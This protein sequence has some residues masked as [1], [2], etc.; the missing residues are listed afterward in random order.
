M[1]QAK[2]LP[3]RSKVKG[4]GNC[5]NKSQERT[6]EYRISNRRTAEVKIKGKDEIII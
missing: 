3:R 6:E 2:I 5:K 4:K 1:H